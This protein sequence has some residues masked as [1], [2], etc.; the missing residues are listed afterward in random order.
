[1]YD[2]QAFL[3]FVKSIHIR[4]YHNSGELNG[5]SFFILPLNSPEGLNRL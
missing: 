2:L 3:I 5:E 4:K 1:M